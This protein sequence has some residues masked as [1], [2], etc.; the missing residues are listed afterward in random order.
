MIAEI[1]EI[2]NQEIRY[3]DWVPGEI[4]VFDIDNS[5]IR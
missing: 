3:A 5:K 4:K 1:L 2:E